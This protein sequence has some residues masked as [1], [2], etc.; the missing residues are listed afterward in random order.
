LVECQYLLSKD[1]ENGL[2]RVA[3]LKP[4]RSGCEVRSFLVFTFAKF[5]PALNMDAKLEFEVDVDGSVDMVN[6]GE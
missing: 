3:G 4:G 2:R 1:S 6:G 5:R